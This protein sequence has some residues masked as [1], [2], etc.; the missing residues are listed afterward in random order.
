MPVRAAGTEEI[1]TVGGDAD[2]PVHEKGE[3]DRRRREREHVPRAPKAPAAAELPERD[4][5]DL[6]QDV[7]E[8]EAVEATGEERPDGR[9]G[10]VELEVVEKVAR[11]AGGEDARDARE[12]DES[13]GDVLPRLGRLVRVVTQRG[14]HRARSQQHE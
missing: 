2:R 4:V 14:E 6:P 13:A 10:A 11:D 12:P 7:V 3:R 1:P 8:E 9:E 5:R